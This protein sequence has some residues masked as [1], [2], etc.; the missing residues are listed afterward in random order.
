M[1]V[2]IRKTV[3]AAV[4]ALVLP[5][6]F[7]CADR[8]AVAPDPETSNPIASP[9]TDMS[10]LR[11]IFQRTDEDGRTRLYT[12]NGDGTHVTKLTVGPA[13]FS[14][15]VSP[16]GQ[17]LAFVV[18]GNGIYTVNVDG[19]N[20]RQLTTV[21]GSA[22]EWSPDGMKIAFANPLTT[23]ISV[24]NAD[25]SGIVHLTAGSPLDKVDGHPSWSPDGKQ[26]T[27]W[28]W[29][30]MEFSVV[31]IMN[32][33]GSGA[34]RLGRQ[35]AGRTWASWGPI[36]SGDSKR[37]VFVGPN[38]GFVATIFSMDPDGSKVAEVASFPAGLLGGMDDRS[39]DGRWMTFT[40]ND[41]GSTDVYLL[42]GNTVY[43]VTNDGRSS[44]AAFLSR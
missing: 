24:I 36:W 18:G 43:R 39:T 33:D 10:S 38:D 8:G 22:P 21:N 9:T 16:D 41:H 3:S 40:G 20:L 2:T 32:S 7:A 44:N 13:Q 30:D 37:I 29:E 26:I 34:K 5:F 19:T 15:A 28:R 25:G 23:G 1:S 42:S 14:P 27:F 35:D 4:T 31:W 6:L 12:M 17:Q 11:L